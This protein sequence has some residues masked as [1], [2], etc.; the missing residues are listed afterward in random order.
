MT[1]HTVKRG[2]HK[3]WQFPRIYFR[4]SS[5]RWKFSFTDSCVYSVPGVDQLDYNKLIGVG[6]LP[7]HHQYS[8]RLGWRW[9]GKIELALYAYQEGQRTI[10]DLGPVEI[11]RVYEVEIYQAH[12]FR[13]L[14]VWDGITNI[15]A[16]SIECHKWRWWAYRMNLYMGGQQPAQHDTTVLIEAL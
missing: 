12:N 16:A 10:I 6:F 3:K 2:R 1:P 8:I 5:W 13:S 7:N 11:G 9:N 4:R 15:Y 14:K